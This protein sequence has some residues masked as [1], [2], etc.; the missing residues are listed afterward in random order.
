[1][2]S[3][4]RVRDIVVQSRLRLSS[5]AEFNDPFDMSGRAGI[6]GAPMEIRG[7][8]E[9]A[10]KERGAK[11]NERK[12]RVAQM[13]SNGREG[14]NLRLQE[15]FRELACCAGVCSFGGDP[16]SILMWTIMLLITQAF[17][18]NLKLPEISSLS[19]TLY[20]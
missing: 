10:L 4:E 18:S 13:M 5:P 17:A 1:M 9:K 20:P 8:L 2:T 11:R 7:M 14:M 6:E 19:P 15:V 16:R 12:K 3:V